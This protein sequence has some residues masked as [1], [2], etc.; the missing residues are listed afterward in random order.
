MNTLQKEAP[1]PIE[2]GRACIDQNYRTR[3]ILFLLWAGLAKYMT[4][5]EK[6][7]LFGCCSLTGTDPRLGLG[8]LRHLEVAGHMHP[9]LHVSPLPGLE[10]RSG[11]GEPLPFGKKDL[12]KLFGT[13]LRSGA[14]ACGPPAIDRQF[15]TIDFLVV[16]DV[17]AMDRDLFGKFF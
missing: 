7:Y 1:R 16:L 6:R 17:E 10:C 4:R 9:D 13:Y 2:I 11:D 5:F 8:A 12:P 3:R 14:L 15:K